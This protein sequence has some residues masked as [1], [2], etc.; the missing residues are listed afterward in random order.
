MNQQLF[1]EM[2]DAA[3]NGKTIDLSEVDEEFIKVAKEQTFLPFLYV[4]S[5]DKKYK[6]YYI[7]SVLIHEKINEVG[8]LIDDILNEAKIPHIFLK[9]Y[10]LQNLYPDSN[11]RMMGDIDLIVKPEDF[12]KAAKSILNVELFK[13]E[14]DDEHHMGIIANGIEVE[15][16]HNLFEDYRYLSLY[17][18]D[19]FVVSKNNNLYKYELLHNAQLIYILGHY[20]KHLNGGEGLRPILD[21]YMLLLKD[22]NYPTEELK[23]LGLYD[24]FEMILCVINKIFNINYKVSKNNKYVNDFINYTLYSGIHG[25]N[26]DLN[27]KEEIVYN[28]KQSKFLFIISKIFC[29][30]KDIFRQYKWSKLIIT[31]PLAYLCRFFFLLKTKKKKIN[32]FMATKKNEYNK[33]FESIKI[34]DANNK[35]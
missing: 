19:C 4:A 16:H 14:Y 27:Q 32:K 15:L 10:E 6:K 34:M 13:F 25:R 21:I 12:D 31:L 11:L 2:I 30:I 1:L 23:K 33:M 3:I 20:A 9:G 24:F 5:K 17:F 8:K 29:P 26:L 35:Y 22:N 7:Q 18:D 28:K